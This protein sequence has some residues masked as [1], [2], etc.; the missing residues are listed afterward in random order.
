[1]NETFSLPRLT[2]PV[3]LRCNLK[4]RRCINELQY[5]DTPDD[6]TF[7]NFQRDLAAFFSVVDHVGK[8]ELTGGEPFLRRDLHR[9][10]TEGAGYR[11]RFDFM[12]IDTNGTIPVDPELVR[13]IEPHRDVCE[14][15]ISDYGDIS[16]Y[17]RQNAEYLEERGV[18]CVVRKYYGDDAYFGGWV[19]NGRVYRRNHTPDELKKVYGE[20]EVF[21]GLKG[22]WLLLNGQ[23]HLCA[24]SLQ[25][26]THGVIPSKMGVDYVYIYDNGLDKTEMREMVHNLCYSDYIIACDYCDGSL[27]TSDPSKRF[28]PAEQA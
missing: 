10:V 3:T 8:F 17:A 20:C 21:K 19:D 9:F 22:C 4:C 26:T 7:E 14:V 5:F 2:I 12:R 13:A 25:G 16:K 6:L 18:R 23:L 11:D 24:R 1:M 15:F 27:G 28:V